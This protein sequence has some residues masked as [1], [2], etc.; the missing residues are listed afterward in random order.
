MLINHGGG[1][2]EDEIR[3][4]MQFASSFPNVYLE[5]GYWK[6]EHYEMAIHDQNVTCKRLIWGGG[7]HG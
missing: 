1:Q 5:T 4:A 7:R 2:S 3:E 6:A